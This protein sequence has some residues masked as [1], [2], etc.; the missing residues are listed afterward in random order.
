MRRA[1]Y[2]ACSNVDLDL[3]NRLMRRR[4]FGYGAGAAA[5]LLVLAA[6]AAA[7]VAMQVPLQGPTAGAATPAVDCSP[8]P[9]ANVRGYTLWVSDVSVDG[10][11]VSMM[12]TFKN[13]SVA[14]HASPEDLQLIDSKQHSSGLVTDATGCQTWSRHEFNNGALFGA[15][16]ACFRAS[17]PSPPLVLRWSPDFGLFCCQANIKLT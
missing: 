17:A 7:F 16:K 11:L 4:L 9:C 6:A 13:S 10:D 3:M 15:L 5:I 12:I 1:A 8:P 14:S 2:I